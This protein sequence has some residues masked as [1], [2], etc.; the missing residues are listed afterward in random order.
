[1]IVNRLIC[2]KIGILGL[3]YWLIS[4]N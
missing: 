1:V 3:I 4:T 2:I